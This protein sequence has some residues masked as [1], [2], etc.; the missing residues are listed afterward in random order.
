MANNPFNRTIINA[1]E[2]PMSPDINRAQSSLD[3]SIRALLASIYTGRAYAV[4]PDGPTTV[5]PSGFIGEAFKVRPAATPSMVLTVKKGFGFLYDATVLSDINSIGGLDDLSTWKPTVLNA[6]VTFTVPSQPSGNGRKDIVEIKT[7]NLQI[8]EPTSRDVFNIS[9]GEFDANTVNKTLAWDYDGGV[10]I[11]PYGGGD[12]TAA[13]ALKQGQ[14]LATPVAPATSVGYTKIAEILVGGG[15]TAIDSDV[16]LD[17]RTMLFPGGT[18]TIAAR[19]SVSSTTAQLLLLNAAPGVFA[20]VVHGGLNLA[21]HA[22]VD[23]Y[24]FSGRMVYSAI[25]TCW[26]PPPNVTVD[27]EFAINFVD[28]TMQTALKGG[29]ASPAVKVAIGQI[30]AVARF[31]VDISTGTVPIQVLVSLNG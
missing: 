8:G 1:R 17:N 3:R 2:R 11:N 15:V 16:I 28:L 29:A 6:D 5:P 9:T 27:C 31:E 12:S 25:S 18:H 26:I 19:M 4:Y 21:G 30:M 22:L 24:I 7:N 14:T 13:I 10:Q 23:V 20:S